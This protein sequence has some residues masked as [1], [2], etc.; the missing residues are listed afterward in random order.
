MKF[1]TLLVKK[2]GH[3]ATVTLNQPERMNP[4]N[5]VFFLEFKQ[6]LEELK[7]DT[8]CQFI[9]FTAAG[10]A[11]SCGFDMSPEAI[12]D[13]FKHRGLQN[14]RQW[15][16]FSQDVMNTMENLEQITIG[17]VNGVAVGGGC[18]LLLNC[19]FRIASEKA[20]FRIPET[21]LGMP[22]SWGSTPRLV[23]LI[24]PSYTKE[25]I[26]TAEK[27]S[28]AEAYRMGLVNKVVPHDK[29][30]PSCHEL[31][32]KLSLSGPLALRM[33]KKQV[34]AASTV[35]NMDL[36]LFEADLM[37]LCFNSGDTMEGIFAFMEKRR[38]NFPSSKG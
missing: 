10:K 31:I 9:I 23:S 33:C 4:L 34:N 6:A 17:A 13:R 11:F 36:Y 24:G 32:E 3:T 21:R 38:P 26:M 5:A 7:C 2:S 19:D 12:E 15:Q 14:E 28:A 22:L 18:C 30:L 27:I 29:L 37:D 16:S 20:A 1:K 35:R 25:L 8:K